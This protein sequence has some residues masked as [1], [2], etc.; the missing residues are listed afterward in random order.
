VYE[1]RIVWYW[2][3]A[4]HNLHVVTRRFTKANKRTM[5]LRLYCLQLCNRRVVI[6]T[7]AQQFI[8]CLLLLRFCV[9]DHLKT[10]AE[11]LCS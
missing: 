1:K 6:C 5:N 2:W 11:F 9:A 10:V 7:F 8:V 4:V 3:Y